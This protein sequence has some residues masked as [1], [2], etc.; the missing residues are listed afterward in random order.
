[1]TPGGKPTLK[2][3]TKTDRNALYARGIASTALATAKEALAV[4]PAAT[5]A[6]ILVVRPASNSTAGLEAVFAGTYSRTFLRGIDWP[7]H[8]DPLLVALEGDDVL[9]ATKGVTREISPLTVGEDS[10]AAELL[11][12][13]GHAIATN[14][15]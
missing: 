14:S 13:L 5:E 8:P 10:S 11:E 2:K 4:A 3:R 7:C 6:R 15:R 12:A 1:V 9:Y